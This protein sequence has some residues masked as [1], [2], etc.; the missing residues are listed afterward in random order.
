MKKTLNE[1][2]LQQEAAFWDAL[3]KAARENPGKSCRK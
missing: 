3:K 1:K 2:A